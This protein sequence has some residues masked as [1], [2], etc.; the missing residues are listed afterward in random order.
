M[1]VAA[2]AAEAALQAAMSGDDL[3]EL[4]Q[5]I[6]ENDQVAPSDMLHAARARRNEFWQAPQPT[7]FGLFEGGRH[8]V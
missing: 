8:S 1:E 6:A 4:K 5:R 7:P 3:D 2:A